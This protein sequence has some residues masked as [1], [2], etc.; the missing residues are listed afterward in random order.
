MYE[1]TT[2]K[3]RVRVRPEYLED[4]SDPSE[5]RYFWAYHIEI[6]NEG[7]RTVKL[8]SRYWRITDAFGRAEEVRG[9]GVVGKQPVLKPGE[10]FS[11]SSGAPLPTASGFMVGRYQMVRDDGGRFEIDIPAFSLD[12]P[13]A[14]ESIH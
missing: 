3:M 10:S 1:K 13:W 14:S 9:S 5:G 8:L 6:V 2:A 7:D 4:H 12:S 11:Y